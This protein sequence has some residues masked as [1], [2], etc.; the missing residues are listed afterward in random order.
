MISGYVSAPKK[1][2]D[3]RCVSRAP[4]PVSTLAARTLMCAVEAVG[5]VSSRSIVPETSVNLPRTVVTIM[6]LAEKRT[7]VWAGSIVNVVMV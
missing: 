4:K 5:S 7:S 1:S 2:S 6:C 3:R